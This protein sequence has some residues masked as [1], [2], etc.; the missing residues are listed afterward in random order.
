[1]GAVAS[2]PPGAHA[3][4][5]DARR[6]GSVLATGVIALLL[7]V[8]VGTSELRRTGDAA[9]YLAMTEQLARWHQPALSKGDVRDEE[10]RQER[11]GDG[12]AGVH[13]TNP[14]L[15]ADGRQD[16]SH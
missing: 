1:M 8:L 2:R 7:I 13:L 10:A 4:S 9:Q 5:D 3:P 16:Y 11:I 12:Y 15:R 14:P 6:F